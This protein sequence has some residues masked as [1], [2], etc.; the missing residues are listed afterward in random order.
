MGNTLSNQKYK[1]FD[2]LM[3]G[4]ESDL[5]KW[6]DEGYLDRGIFIKTIRKVNAFL[7]LKIN[8]EREDMIEVKNH[9]ALLPGD[10]QFLQLALACQ[11]EYVRGP[12]LSG[13]Q[14]ESHTIPLSNKA[15]E[16]HSCSG[17][18]CEGP[19]NN[20]IWITQKIGIKTQTFTD[21]RTLELTN[22]SRS[23]CTDTCLNFHFRSPHQIRIQEDHATFSFTEGLVYINYIADMLDENNNILILDH[24]LV[25]DYYEYAVKEAFFENMFLNKE[26][27]FLQVYQAMQAKLRLA[28]IQAMGFVNTPEYGDIQKMFIDNRHRFYKRYVGYFTD[29]NQGY[30]KGE[31][32]SDNRLFNERRRDIF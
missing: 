8:M 12:V 2:Q 28:K 5:G 31:K 15:C 24:P 20:C 4:V 10:F 9:V 30:F 18:E 3:A 22:S 29:S 26:G 19:C 13:A 21:I 23:R 11:T 27:D 7:G 14:T 16:M 1:S 6:A 25:N 17:D 32:R